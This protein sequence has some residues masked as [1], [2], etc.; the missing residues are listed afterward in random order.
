MLV[1]SGVM[2][3][4]QDRVSTRASQMLTGRQSAGARAASNHQHRA[5]ALARKKLVRFAEDNKLRT[6]L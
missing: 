1:L 3:Q 2:I 4:A 5:S 6:N